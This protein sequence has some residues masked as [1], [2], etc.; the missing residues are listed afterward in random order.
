MTPELQTPT[1]HGAVDDELRSKDGKLEFHV[2]AHGSSRVTMNAKGKASA[3]VLHDAIP[4][5]EACFES[6][7]VPYNSIAAWWR[8][9][10][11]F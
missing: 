11:L 7:A 1:V 4:L 10:A 2:K 9:S 3:R 5:M 8:W 6:E